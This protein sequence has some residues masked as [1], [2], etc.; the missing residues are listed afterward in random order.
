MANSGNRFDRA[1]QRHSATL[2][3]GTEI[4]CK[5]FATLSKVPHAHAGAIPSLR[6]LVFMLF[7]P[8]WAILPVVDQ[9]P[10]SGPLAPLAQPEPRRVVG[11]RGDDRRRQHRPR[12]RHLDA[13]RLH[14]RRQ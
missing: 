10:I 5:R 9:H 4:L 1:H 6:L 14:Q 2:S 12:A 11:L 3:Q 7:A 8:L 13:E